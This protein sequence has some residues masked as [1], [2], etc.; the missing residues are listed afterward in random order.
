MMR[1]KF[2]KINDYLKEIPKKLLIMG[3]GIIGLEMGTVYQ[4]LGSTID[5]VEMQ[6]QL[7]PVADKD[8]IKMYT[9]ANSKRFNIMLKT[10][11]AKVEAKE[12]GI[13]VSM[14]GEGVQTEPLIYDAVLVPKVD[15]TFKRLRTL[16]FN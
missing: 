7:V 4:K 5:V 12:D 1:E 2:I 15:E 11:V 3:G 6:D 13:H 14:E 10:K 16:K 8:V 9:K